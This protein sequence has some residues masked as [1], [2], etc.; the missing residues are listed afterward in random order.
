MKKLQLA[1]AVLLAIPL[2]VFGTNAFLGFFELPDGEPSAGAD[3]LRLM[4][5]GGLMAPIALSHVVV[6]LMLLVPKLRFTAGVL[7]LPMSIG[8]LAFHWTMLPE[9][10]GPAIGMLVLN[11]GVLTD[12]RRWMRLIFD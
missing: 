6:G 7:Q 8:I 4:R 3:L 1:C 9:G 5:D 2:V 12:E 10:L 11:L